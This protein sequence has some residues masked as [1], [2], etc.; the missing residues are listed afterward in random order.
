[1]KLDL[2][3]KLKYQTLKYYQLVLNIL[4]A[5]YFLTSIAM[6]DPQTSYIYASHITLIMSALSLASARL[7][8]L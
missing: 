4:C 8:K 7:G 1:M 6:P 5:T 2:F 3:G